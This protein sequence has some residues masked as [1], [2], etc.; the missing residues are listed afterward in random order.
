MPESSSSSTS[1]TDRDPNSS[2]DPAQGL[3]VDQFDGYT[4]PIIDETNLSE[5]KAVGL[6]VL[7]RDEDVPTE[8]PTGPVQDFE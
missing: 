6:S 1:G 5:D 2:P 3:P 7:W 8:Q 4:E